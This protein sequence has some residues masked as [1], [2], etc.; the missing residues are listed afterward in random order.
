MAA[1]P[2]CFATA[3]KEEQG[4]KERQNGDC[5][6]REDEKCD[7]SPATLL[8]TSHQHQQNNAENQSRQLIVAEG[9]QEH[10]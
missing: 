9:I 6:G 8:A 3:D 5:Q 10:I 7:S 1:D 2:G 4:V